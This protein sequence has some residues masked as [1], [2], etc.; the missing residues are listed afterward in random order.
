VRLSPILASVIIAAPWIGAASVDFAVSA[1]LLSKYDR[2]GA[3]AQGNILIAAA[4]STCTL[5]LVNSLYT[6]GPIWIGK[7]DPTGQ[8]L[9]FATY[10]GD[11]TSTGYAVVA[12]IAADANGNLIVAADTSAPGMPTVNAIQASPASP[13]STLYLAKLAPDGSSLLYAT[14]LGGSGGQTALSLAV[15]SAG[16]A[17]VAANPGTSDFPTTPQSAHG[18][19]GPYQTAIAKLGPDGTL[20][21]AVTFPFEFYSDVKPVQVDVAGNATLASN[22]ELMKVAPDGSSLSRTPLPGWAVTARPWVLP[23][24]SGG[25]ALAGT[26]SGPLPVS[27]NALE[28]FDDFNVYVRIAGGAVQRG[29]LGASAAGFAVDPQNRGRI[30][31]ATAGGLY[32]SD[33]NGLSWNL[34]RGG[35]A[36][37]ITVD[38]FD[39]N[40]LYLSAGGNPQMYRSLDGGATWAAISALFNATPTSIAADPNVPGLVYAAAHSLYRSKDGGDTWDYQWVGPSMANISP[41]AALFTTSVTVAADPSHAG[42]AYVLGT[43]GCIGFCPVTQNLSRTQD[44]GATW[45][46]ATAGPDPL[47]SSGGLLALDPATG[48]VVEAFHSFSAQGFL[49]PPAGAVIYRGGNFGPPQVLYPAEVTA[50]AFDPEQPGTIYLATHLAQGSSSGYYVLE[51]ADDGATWT[52]VVQLDRPVT[53]LTVG[54]GGVLHATQSPNPPVG[55][56]VDTDVQGNVAYGTYLGGAFTQVNA[57]AVSGGLVTIAGTTQGGLPPAGA[58]PLA[59]AGDTDGFVAV[60]DESGTLMWSTYLGGSSDDSIDQAVPL[61]DGSVLVVGTTNSVDFPMLHEGPLGP[62]NVFLAR[63]RQGQ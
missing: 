38:P 28:T 48:D 21:Y 43:T 13:Y 49:A 31:A 1:N 18:G 2:F 27:A 47:I 63:V 32:R 7:L 30:Y 9:L 35:A 61:A 60:F 51:S 55:Y 20:Q 4:R 45:S 50:V 5:P 33:D 24:A 42:W 62:G 53:A 58:A 57:A 39:S 16:A 6:C 56:L 36:L 17:Y 29:P 22:V 12:G 26:A 41:S 44:E 23:R 34:V 14:Y 37:A 40:R 10:L 46:G 19:P 25:F 54:D 8:R 52:S 3:D 15:D 11:G 59:Y